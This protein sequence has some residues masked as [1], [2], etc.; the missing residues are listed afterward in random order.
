MG[1]V[2]I[3]Q[4]LKRAEVAKSDSDF[5][6]FFSL[7]LAAEALAKTIVLGIVAAIGDDKDRHRYRLEH[8]LVRA[9]GLQCPAISTVHAVL[10]RHGLVNRKGPRRPR[11]E[12]TPLAWPDTPKLC[13]VR[14]TRASSCWPTAGT[15]I[16]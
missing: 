4:V 14:T 5:T 6:Y 11:A 3:D 7:L 9:E 13:G 2:A 10:D 1:H 16:P 12:G 15:A 8:Q